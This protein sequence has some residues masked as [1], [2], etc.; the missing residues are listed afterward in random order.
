MED[1]SAKK[2]TDNK[3]IPL[4]E[5]MGTINHRDAGLHL[6]EDHLQEVLFR[7]MWI[8]ERYFFSARPSAKLNVSS[9]YSRMF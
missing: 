2:I 8:Q 3:G 5:G 9:V 7:P 4:K 1:F 6:I